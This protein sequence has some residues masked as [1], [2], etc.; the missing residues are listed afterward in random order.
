[1]RSPGQNSG[2]GPKADP[3]PSGWGWSEYLAALVDEAGTLTAIAWKL[4]E[5]ADKTHGPDAS[6][7]IDGT[8]DVASVERALRRLRSR[9]QRDGGIWGQR[10]LRHFGVPRAIED[11]LRWMGLYH[12]PFNDLPLPLCDDQLRLWDHPPISTSRARLWLLLAA[13]SCAL[14]R[15]DFAKA[16]TTLDDAQKILQSV[17]RK[18]GDGCDSDDAMD[19][20]VDARIE[21]ALAHAY[22]QSRTDDAAAVN[23]SLAAAQRDLHSPQL[24]PDDRA[25][26]VARLCDQQAF[27]LNRRADHRAALQLYQALPTDDVHPFASYRRDAG[28]AYGYLQLG[29]RDLA[30]QHAQRA[31][32]HAG[33]GG[34]TRLRVMSLILLS[35][36]DP[37]SNA[38]PRA[39]AIAQRLGDDELLLR[40]S[41][42]RTAQAKS[43]PDEPPTTDKTDPAHA[44][45]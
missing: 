10:L 4:I 25:C 11:R 16:Q 5:R 17:G 37:H 40:V 31:T 20:R 29:Q 26:F 6:D 28:L 3:P 39:T 45:K 22:L 8:D 41:R 14:R 12:S 24:S 38:L 32:Q 44:A 1:M 13:A 27:A 21:A 42:A 19:V 33:D 9:G 18:S 23:Q 2:Q 30:R 35:R 34:Y 43:P 7:R 36:I 15:R